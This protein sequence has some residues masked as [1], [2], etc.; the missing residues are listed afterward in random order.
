MI[1]VKHLYL[2]LFDNC[3]LQYDKKTL[4]TH[5]KFTLHDFLLNVHMT[6]ANVSA[7]PGDFDIGSGP[8]KLGG[9]DISYLDWSF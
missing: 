5:Q 7:M 6:K 1:H 3:G 4:A 9:I 8:L 2:S